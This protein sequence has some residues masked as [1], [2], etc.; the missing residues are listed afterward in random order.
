MQGFSFQD[1]DVD[2]QLDKQYTEQFNFGGGLFEKKADASDAGE[3]A[4]P[5]RHRS[6]KEVCLL[7]HAQAVLPA[8][9]PMT[10]SK[11]TVG[12]IWLEYVHYTQPHETTP[13]RGWHKCSV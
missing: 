2:E 1:D 12:H 4:D 9:N 7:H 8:S 13:S 3:A 5:D 6:K 10:M 11:L